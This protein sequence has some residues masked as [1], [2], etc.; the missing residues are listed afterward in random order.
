MASIQSSI[1]KFWF[2]RLNLFG[3]G[4]YDPQKLRNRIEHTSMMSRPHRKVR[5]VPVQ[6]DSVPSEWLIPQGAP[7]DRTLLYLHG[8]AWIMGSAKTHRGFVS[9]LAY[10]SGIR[11]L[12]INYRLA[13]ENPFPAGLDDCMMTYEWL[14][15]SGISADKIVVA[16]DSAGGNLALALLVALRDADKPLPAGAVALSPATDLALTGESRK[17]RLQL[18][19]VLSNLG[20][21][22]IIKDYITNHDPHHPYISPLY[23]DLRGLP[24]LLIHVG[25]HETLLDDAVRFGECAQA[26]GVNAQTVVWPEMFHVFQIFTP[27]LPE[28]RKAVAQIAA[29][30]KSRMEDNSADLNNA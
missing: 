2:R 26:A 27:I 5:V 11:A 14:L 12:L 7:Q 3:S 23:A 15:H 28:A 25:D 18:D 13:P 17:T 6:A 19:P 1:L 21:F 22:P 10:A 29:F 30:V 16:G 20:S 4:I 9:H 24:P 8:G